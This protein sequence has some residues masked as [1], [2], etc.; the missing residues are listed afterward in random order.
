[1]TL[2]DTLQ[3][4]YEDPCGHVSE[5]LYRGY[6]AGAKA[7]GRTTAE[8]IRG[9][10]EQYRVTRLRSKGSLADLQPLA[11]GQVL[12]PLGPDDDLLEEMLDADR[13]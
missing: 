9:A 4:M 13:G 7:H 8:R 3:T 11:L 2:R 10:M 6:Q 12:R 5:P 1:M